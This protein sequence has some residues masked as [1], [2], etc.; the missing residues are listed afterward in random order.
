MYD[1]GTLLGTTTPSGT[2]N[3]SFTPT[4]PLADGPHSFTATATDSA[5]NT[6][7]TSNTYTITVDTTLPAPPVVTFIDAMSINGTAQSNTIISIYK[8]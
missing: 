4:T 6:S 5:G 1:A 7:G 3:W 2:G 8:R